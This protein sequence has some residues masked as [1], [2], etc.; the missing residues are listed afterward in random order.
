VELNP[1][2]T[3]TVREFAYDE[4]LRNITDQESGLEAIRG[5][6][7]TLLAATYIVTGFLGG[8]SLASPTIT[9][10]VVSRPPVGDWGWAAIGAFV[11]VSVLNLVVML[12]LETWRFRM[13]PVKIA[14]DAESRE[15]SLSEVKWDLARHHWDNYQAN[16][17]KLARLYWALI[18]AA[19]GL[20]AETIFWI[21]EL[22]GEVL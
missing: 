19:L 7:G 18:V 3:Q 21:L 4:A 13:N 11:V 1:E 22:R 12:P 16:R 17:R 8:L 5:R 2:L 6:A 9:A 14:T 10:G 15:L 20:V